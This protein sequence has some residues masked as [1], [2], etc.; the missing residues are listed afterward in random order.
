MLR[1]VS[2]TGG[3]TTGTI[4]PVTDY[5][6]DDDRDRKWYYSIWLELSGDV[7]RARRMAGYDHRDFNSLVDFE[8]WIDEQVYQLWESY[9][10]DEW[11]G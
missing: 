6:D 7:G 8:D 3:L 1:A 2:S 10:L 9:G 4:C 11:E 5:T